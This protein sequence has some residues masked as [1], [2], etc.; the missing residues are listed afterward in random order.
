MSAKENAIKLCKRN[1][2]DWEVGIN[3]SFDEVTVNLLCRNC[4]ATCEATGDVR[5]DDGRFLYVDIEYRY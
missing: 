4:E 3:D 5:A 2:H 1:G